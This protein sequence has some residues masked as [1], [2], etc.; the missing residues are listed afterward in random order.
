MRSSRRRALTPQQL[1]RR[2]EQM[3]PSRFIGYDHDSLG[4]HL[5]RI[6]SLDLAESELRRAVWLNP[7]ELRFVKHLAWCLYRKGKYEE[8]QD[9]ISKALALDG[10]DGE[11]REILR[12]IDERRSS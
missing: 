10:A 1:E 7:F 3:R 11:G 8:A 4:L 2:E 9:W 12:L 5:L 6:G